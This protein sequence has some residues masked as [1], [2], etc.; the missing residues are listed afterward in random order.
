MKKYK[1][2]YEVSKR[3]FVE[4]ENEA[5]AIEKVLNGEVEAEDDEM[6]TEAEAIEIDTI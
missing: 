3:A 2:V 5:E 4:A 6:T 1:V